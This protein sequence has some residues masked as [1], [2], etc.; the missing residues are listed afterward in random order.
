MSVKLLSIVDRQTNSLNVKDTQI[1]RL[2]EISGTLVDKLTP[3]V[4]KLIKK[5]LMIS[6]MLEMY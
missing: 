1:G 6:I 4:E 3:L 5:T 2:I